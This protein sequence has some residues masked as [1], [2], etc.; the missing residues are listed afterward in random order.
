MPVFKRRQPI[1]E[2]VEPWQYT[3]VRFLLWPDSDMADDG[4]YGE[5]AAEVTFVL[6]DR[7]ESRLIVWLYPA[8]VDGVY[9]VGTRYRFLIVTD[10]EGEPDF[11]ADGYADGREEA[12]FQRVRDVWNEIR[13]G[14]LSAVAYNGAEIYPEIFRWDGRPYEPDDDR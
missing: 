2:T 13:V 1:S 3:D 12:G 7:P 11:V 4:Q 10:P 6:P 9:V 5:E 14:R 8:A